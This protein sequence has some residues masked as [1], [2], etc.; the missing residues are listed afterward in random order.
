MPALDPGCAGLAGLSDLDTAMTP[1]Q[2]RTIELL[3]HADWQDLEDETV[4]KIR[5]L[6]EVVLGVKEDDTHLPL[7]RDAIIPV[8]ACLA[9]FNMA[10]TI[11]EEEISVTSASPF[12]GESTNQSFNIGN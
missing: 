9:R 12:D 6:K 3:K 4:A 10:I 7:M 2:A 1:T 11:N 8:L 5:A